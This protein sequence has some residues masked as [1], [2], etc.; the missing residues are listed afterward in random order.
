MV[1]KKR[2]KVVK[3]RRS[4]THGGGAMK[5][6]RGAGNRGGRGMAG[7]G[8]RADQKKPSIIKEFGNSYFGKHG[9]KRPPSAVKKIKTINIGQIE[10]VFPGKKDID[11]GKEGYSKLLGGG[12]INSKIKIKVDSAS[13]KAIEK[14]KEKGGDVILPKEPVVEEVKAPEEPIES[15]PE[16][17]YADSTL[18][19]AVNLFKKEFIQKILEEHSGNQTEASDS[20]GIQRTYLSRLIKELD[21]KR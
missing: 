11:L 6:R 13:S 8:K 12:K 10:E 19:D 17:K 18:K 15:S 7:S 1:V 9:F 16:E 2:K 20:L 4:K 21:I 5:K 3:Y 14:I